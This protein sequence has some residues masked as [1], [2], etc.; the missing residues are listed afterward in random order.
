MKK[1][2]SQ[3]ASNAF[4]CP[5]CGKSFTHKGHFNEHVKIHSG[6][7]P[8]SC[9]H[10][11]KSFTCRGH[12]K[13]HI[14][15]HTGER[16]Y[17]CDQC[18]KSF[19]CATNLKD[20]QRSHSGERAFRCQQ[21]GKS[22]ILASNLKAHLKIH[23][24]EKPYIC[25]VC[26]KGFLR[27]GCFSDHQKIHSGERASAHVLRVRRHVHQIQRSEAAPED[28]QRRETLQLLALR[29]RALLTRERTPKR[30]PTS[31]PPAGGASLSPA[32]C[33]TTERSPVPCCLAPVQTLCKD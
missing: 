20:H 27:L 10:C 6:V 32:I 19:K 22:F 26:G 29:G 33:R 16:P 15:I 18:G 7:K 13:R 30:D 31:A 23:T 8:F 1:K 3:E 28:P 11:Q 25:G 14:R 5:E 17:A 9:P 24:D 4:V 21:C 2:P 12:L